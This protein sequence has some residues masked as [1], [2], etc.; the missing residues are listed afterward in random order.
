MTSQLFIAVNNSFTLHLVL[1]LPPHSFLSILK[2]PCWVVP[3]VMIPKHT[4]KH[5]SV[6]VQLF[7]TA[8]AGRAVLRRDNAGLQL[9]SARAQA[10]LCCLVSAPVL[11]SHGANAQSCL[12]NINI[13]NS[14]S[15]LI[16]NDI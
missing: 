12:E 7:L 1:L 4:N 2:F 10:W 9:G 11:L 15:I 16:N 8:I 5:K 13:A 3:V 6:S 14:V